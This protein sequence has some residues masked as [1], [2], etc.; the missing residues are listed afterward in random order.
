MLRELF[1]DDY[2]TLL[3]SSGQNS[4]DLASQH[5]DIAAIVMDIKMAGMDGI[6]AAREI[7]NICPDTP[8]IFHTGYP[9]DY[10]EDEIDRSEQ[11]FDFVLKGDAVSRLIRSVRNAVEAYDLKKDRAQLSAH[12][13]TSYGMI[14]K[15]GPMQKV[16]SLIRKV[17]AS[18]S[19]A[20]IF[21]ETGTGKEL[22]ARAIHNTGRRQNRRLAILNCHRK[23]PELVESELFGHVKGAFTGAVNERPGLFEYANRGTVFLDEV[24]DL[25][26]ATQAK[27][28]RVLENGEYTKIGSEITHNTDVRILCATH[29]DLESLIEDGTFRED[30]YFRLKGVT[31]NL[32]PLR[33]RQEDIP[34]LIGKFKD[35][36]TIEMGLSPKVFEPVAIETLINYNW[37]G[38]V[39]QLLETVQSL[40]VLSESDLIG[41]DE[42]HKYL[43]LESTPDAQIKGSLTLKIKQYERNII[44]RALSQTNYNISATARL[45]NL[46]R[47]NLRKKIR[48]HNIDLS[49]FRKH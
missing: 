22:V 3:A 5:K 2:E 43:N 8:V 49:G 33:E 17:A 18:D 15:S 14:G 28:L 42:V 41:V 44:V 12:A 40:I 46:D 35:R 48:N 24:A 6:S 30:L 23:S 10:N 27:L 47:T 20:M 26:I 9:G 25:D 13:E 34:L 29:K 31:I 21:G 45:L 7:K 19:K 39:R 4:I 36:F 16:Y 11:P 32:P 37:P 1:E 38:N